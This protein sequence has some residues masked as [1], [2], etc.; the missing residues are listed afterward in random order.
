MV[1]A[2]DDR[3]NVLILRVIKMNIVGYTNLCVS[4]GVNWGWCVIYI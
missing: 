2:G 4:N 3:V 1:Y